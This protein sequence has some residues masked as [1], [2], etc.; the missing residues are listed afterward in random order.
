MVACPRGEQSSVFLVQRALTWVAL[1]CRLPTCQPGPKL[2]AVAR[3]KPNSS[4][5]NLSQAWEDGRS[6]GQC[7]TIDCNSRCCPAVYRRFHYTV[8]TR[9]QRAKEHFERLL[10]TI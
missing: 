8:R 1:C 2:L 4:T 9:P 10:R 5:A 3:H 7:F 6:I